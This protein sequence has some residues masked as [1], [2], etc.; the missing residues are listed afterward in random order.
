VNWVIVTLLFVGLLMLNNIDKNLAR[1]LREL[2][3][4]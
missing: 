3:R 2:R 4:R 1:A